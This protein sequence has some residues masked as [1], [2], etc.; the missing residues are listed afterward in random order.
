MVKCCNSCLNKN[1]LISI[2]FYLILIRHGLNVFLSFFYSISLSIL[3]YTVSGTPFAYVHSY[4]ISLISILIF[5]LAVKNK[6][7]NFWF[8]L[9]VIMGLAF[10]CMQT[11]AAYINVVLIFFSIIYFI[12]NFNL[13]NIIYF[14]LGSIF[15]LF[16]LIIFLLFFEIPFIKFIQQYLLFPIT[17]GE[18]RLVGNEMAHISLAGR[19]TL[20]NVL[21]HFKFINFFLVLILFLTS[22]NYFKKS[23]YF[24]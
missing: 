4:A 21:G 17:I 20:R 5:T 22:I 16:F 11:P 15:V 7:N 19:F 12:F 10:L 14:A 2:S 6:S 9:P 13:K 8:I 23:Y 3:C 1:L 18:N 24:C